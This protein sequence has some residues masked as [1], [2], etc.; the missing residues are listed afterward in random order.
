MLVVGLVAFFPTGRLL[1]SDALHAFLH[2]RS[3]VQIF[4]LSVSLQTNLTLNMHFIV[5]QRVIL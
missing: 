2:R 3:S 4:S 5:L 1:L